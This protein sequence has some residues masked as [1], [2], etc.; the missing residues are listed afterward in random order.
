MADPPH[1]TTSQKADADAKADRKVAGDSATP[2][3][4]KLKR[5]TFADELTKTYS[6][7]T[8][9]KIRKTT[10]TYPRITF[11][12]RSGLIDSNLAKTPD[13]KKNPKA[14]V[15]YPRLKAQVTTDLAKEKNRNTMTDHVPPKF[16]DRT[17]STEQRLVETENPNAEL[18]KVK[19][20]S[21]I[22]RTTPMTGLPSTRLHG[23]STADQRGDDKK[24]LKMENEL[25]AKD[26]AL[27]EAKDD[28]KR[29]EKVVEAYKNIEKLSIKAGDDASMKG[30]KLQMRILDLEKQLKTYKD[31]AE[32]ATCRDKLIEETEARQVAVDKLIQ[33]IEKLK[34]VVGKHDSDIKRLQ[35][36]VVEPDTGMDLDQ[37]PSFVVLNTELSG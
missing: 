1:R 27:Q 18:E 11:A 30:H 23:S 16:S 9:D 17:R 5:P 26:K 4:A 20:P 37:E 32:H 3:M 19:K 36:P 12:E 14:L 31:Q 25:K 28:I 24:F 15:P 33:E 7:I 13:V 34:E 2:F 10:T 8:E 21:L 29:L 6:D 35:S 22:L